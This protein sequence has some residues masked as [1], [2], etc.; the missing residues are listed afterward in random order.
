M[1]DPVMVQPMRDEVTKLGMKEMRTAEDVEKELMAP[2]TAFVFINSVCGCAAGGARPALKLALQHSKKP[3]RLTTAFAG[4]D[5]EAV[6]KARSFF[7]GFP[8]SSP[9]FAIIKNGKL[10]W[11]MERWQIEGRAPE[12]IAADLV[13]V[14][15][16]LD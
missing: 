8:P 1:Y 13:K 5:V 3:D 2:G 14:F 15:D 10:A 6:A 11:M 4:N 9:Q 12:S 16:S 7:T